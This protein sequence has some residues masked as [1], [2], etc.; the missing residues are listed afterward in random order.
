MPGKDAMPLFALDTVRN[1]PID[2]S[3]EILLEEMRGQVAAFSF[4]QHPGLAT[5]E[6]ALQ[7]YDQA[8]PRFN[9]ILSLLTGTV[10]KRG[11]DISTG[12]GFLA[13]LLAGTGAEMCGTEIDTRIA[14]FA[15]SRGIKIICYSIGE[16]PYFA[17]DQSLDFLVLGEVLEHLKQP[18]V[19]VVQEVTRALRPG[20]RFI[21]TTPNVSR[22]AHI[23]AL[24]AGENFLEPF[25][26]SIPPGSDATDS[27][28]HVREYSVRE[29]AEAVEGAG[30]AIE[31][32]LMT[33]WG[34]NGYNPLPNSYANEIIVVCATK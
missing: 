16:A 25:P 3:A 1:A 15:A 29:V 10:G 17:P 31:Q 18:P 9:V 14:A 26:E 13:A 34:Q 22:L 20:G 28:E 5:V 21:L 32:V 33:G 23:E 4:P 12:F 19:R 11:A 27:L 24:A 8:R 6:D 30:L 7:V 2:C